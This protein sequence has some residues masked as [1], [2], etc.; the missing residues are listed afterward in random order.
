MI[1]ILKRMKK[2]R[3][4]GVQAV[5]YNTYVTLKLQNVKSTT[6]TVKGANPCWEQDFLFETNDVNTG[7]LIEVW[8][9]GMLWDNALGYHWIPLPVVKYSNEEGTGQWLSLEAELVMRDGEVVGTKNPTGHSLLVDCRFE[10]PF[11]SMGKCKLC[12]VLQAFLEP[13][14]MPLSQ[15]DPE[16][17]E[18]ADLQRKLELLNSIMDQEA[19][20]EQARRQL[21]YYGH[22]GYSEDSDYTSDLN[23][24]VGQHANS[25][26]SQFRSAAHQMCTPQRSLETSRENSYERDDVPQ[27]QQGQGHHHLHHQH[28]HDDYYGGGG[29]TGRRYSD[30]ESEPLF[31]NS[32]PKNYK[33]Y[34]RRRKNTWDTEDSPD[35]WYGSSNYSGPYSSHEQ[36][37]RIYQDGSSYYHGTTAPAK[38]TR[39]TNRRPSLERQTTLYDDQYYADGYYDQQQQP[40]QQQQQSAYR[41]YDHSQSYSS[42]DYYS[43]SAEYPYQDD[44]YG[45]EDEDRQWDSGG[46]YYQDQYG[47]RDQYENRVNSRRSANRKIDGYATTG[48]VGSQE[49]G[50]DEYYSPQGLSYDEDYTGNEYPP[51]TANAIN[52]TPATTRRRMPHRRSSS[53]QSSVEE[54]DYIPTGGGG[55]SGGYYDDYRREAVTLAT[56]TATTTTSAAYS[57]PATTGRTTQLPKPPSSAHKHQLPPTPVRQLPHHSA[58]DTTTTTTT[59]ATARRNNAPLSRTGSAEYADQDAY[60][61]SRDA[62]SSYYNTPRGVNKESGYNEDYNYAYRS[63]DNLATTQQDSV[64]EDREVIVQDKRTNDGRTSA[65]GTRSYQQATPT[66]QR[67]NSLTQQQPPQQQQP[68]QPQQ[69]QQQKQQTYQ[70][71]NTEE[72]Y[73]NAQDERDYVNEE[74]EEDLGY[75][76]DTTPVRT[77]TRKKFPGGSPLLQQNTDSLESRDDDLRD[78]FETAVSSVSSSLQ[79]RRGVYDYST[80]AETVTPT[81]STTTPGEIIPTSVPV[82]VTTT[83]MTVPVSTTNH[84]P[85]QTTQHRITATLS[86]RD[87]EPSKVV[88]SAIPAVSSPGTAIVTTT[89]T[90]TTAASTTSTV[91]N[92]VLPPQPS[93]H[94]SRGYLRP[95]D[96]LD[97]CAEEVSLH[98]SGTDYYTKSMNFRDSPPSVLMDRYGTDTPVEP[99]TPPLRGFPQE[100]SLIEPYQ[101]SPPKAASVHAS[102]SPPTMMQ[103]QQS[104]DEQSHTSMIES[105]TASGDRQSSQGQAEK[106]KSVSFEDE[107]EVKPERRKMTA[108]ER[109]HWAYNK[110]IM[111][112]NVSTALLLLNGCLG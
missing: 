92:T 54:Y 91:N 93:V 70:R 48:K 87:Q 11:E 17:T 84:M 72:Y 89:T 58:S 68:Q 60:P 27:G 100:N 96:S 45:Q 53:R 23:Y 78:S 15:F 26:A 102:P 47:A 82:P 4:V 107:E 71:Q 63:I 75:Y 24:P 34:S 109:W 12:R 105:P 73:Y 31:Y 21:Q 42:T 56:T 69:Q 36:D 81:T 110:I 35:A 103:K 46:Y 44:R 62:Y 50:E 52:T 2:A 98:S 40:Q 5:N 29:D 20:A 41:G 59:P 95:Q 55:G 76:N 108:K 79:H 65:T 14:S 111:Q 97:S 25:S 86:S 16:N 99:Y 51:P 80:A 18:G 104:L 30:N 106:S 32:R 61:G 66:T 38:R 8:S 94:S 33:E 13:P 67:S 77:D 57:S 28:H 7:L 39:G 10:L 88:A 90:S 9:K 6:V 64:D 74:E 49:E 1:W 19:R 22:S 83:S 112:L 85:P 101:P 37:D 3:Y 43:T